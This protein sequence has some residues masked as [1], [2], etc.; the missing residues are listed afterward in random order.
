MPIAKF[1]LLQNG[2]EACWLDLLKVSSIV[3]ILGAPIPPEGEDLEMED[4][5]AIGSRVGV[6]GLVFDL[7]VQPEDLVALVISARTGR[8]EQNTAA[9]ESPLPN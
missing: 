2:I 8:I 9:V 3:P 6:E 4:I 1:A 7:T 5:R